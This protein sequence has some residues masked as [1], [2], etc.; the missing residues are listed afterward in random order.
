MA[1][2][3]TCRNGVGLVPKGYGQGVTVA[4]YDGDGDPD[5][6]ITRYGPDTLWRNDGGHFTD[7][8]LEAGLGCP[9][10]GLGAAFF[11][12]DRDG[13][14]DLFV[15]NYLKFDEAAA[16]FERDPQTGAARYGAPAEFPGLPD[17]LYRNNGDGTFT[18]VTARSRSGWNGTRHGLPGHRLRWR[19]LARPPR[20]Q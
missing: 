14:L 16:P 17:V 19:W 2:S 12:Y 3:R 11:D 20:C 6:Y 5:V 4:D 1:G 10:W 7:V 18:D 8:T 13:D 9:L 15:A